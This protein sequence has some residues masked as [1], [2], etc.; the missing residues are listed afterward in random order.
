MPRNNNIE[1]PKVKDT[2]RLNVPLLEFVEGIEE[3]PQSKPI[4]AY[5]KYKVSDIVCVWG[6]WSGIIIDIQWS[7]N[8]PNILIYEVGFPLYEDEDEPGDIFYYDTELELGKC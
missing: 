2:V 5:T 3:K 8:D 4:P 7:Q 1:A 6:K